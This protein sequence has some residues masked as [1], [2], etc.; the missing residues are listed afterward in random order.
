[1]VKRIR[2]YTLALGL[3]VVGPKPLSLCAFL[4]STMGDCTSLETQ[5]QCDKMDMGTRPTQWVS[6]VKIFCCAISQAPFPESK[7]EL[8]KATVE[9]ELTATLTSATNAAN[10]AKINPRSM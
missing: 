2:I 6:T 4:S 9:L 10:F 8:S 1:M 5:S 3:A 7:T